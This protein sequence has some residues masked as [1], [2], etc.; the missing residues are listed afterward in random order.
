MAVTSGVLLP[1]LVVCHQHRFLEMEMMII[2]GKGGWVQ[3]LIK[4]EITQ[5]HTVAMH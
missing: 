4:P 3:H 5:N 2:T 1:A